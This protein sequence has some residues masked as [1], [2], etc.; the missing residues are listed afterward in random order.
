MVCASGHLAVDR[1]V[2][3]YRL[4]TGV[5]IAYADNMLCIDN[6]SEFMAPNGWEAEAVQ[7]R[8][9]GVDDL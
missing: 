8:D 4:S 2:L 9:Y 1:S 6:C 3:K 7:H 5:H